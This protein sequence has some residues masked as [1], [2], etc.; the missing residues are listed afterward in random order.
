MIVGYTW[1]MRIPQIIAEVKQKLADNGVQAYLDSTCIRVSS[2]NFYLAYYLHRLD[3]TFWERCGLINWTDFHS[4]VYNCGEN[5]RHKW[6][7]KLLL[8]ELKL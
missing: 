5:T 6:V 8:R 2:G 1:V 3:P 4:A 7:R